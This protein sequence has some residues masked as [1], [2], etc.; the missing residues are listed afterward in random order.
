MHITAD[1]LTRIR[2]AQLRKARYV[3]IPKTNLAKQLVTILSN[4]GFLEVVEELSEKTQTTAKHY[5]RVALPIQKESQKAK[6]HT[7]KV[8]SKP[9]CRVYMNS[10]NIPSPRQKMSLCI[11]STSKGI[12][13]TSEAKLLGVGGEILCTI[14]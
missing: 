3:L 1:I 2:N 8:I 13:T 14:W 11:V 7:M 12:L 6:A 10:K 5:L 9:G 4:E